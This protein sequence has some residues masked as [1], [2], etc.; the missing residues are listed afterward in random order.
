LPCLKQGRRSASQQAEKGGIIVIKWLGHSSFLIT[1]EKGLKIIT[2]PY[3]IGGGISYARIEESADIVTVS[4]KHGDHN[5]IAAV[6]GKPEAVNA[7]GKRSVKGIDFRGIHSYHDDAGGRQRGSNIIFCFTVD[8]MKICHLGDLGQQLD[9]S[10]ITEIGEVDILLL[11]IGGYFTIDARGAGKICEKLNPRIAI[12]MHYKT[13]KCDY[14]IA[15]VDD[16]IKGKKNVR[17]LDTAEVYLKKDRLSDKTEILVLK[18][19]Q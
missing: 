15:G 10:Q 3:S 19:A 7:P 1:S 8:E 17:K 14:P 4:H 18:H 9:A 12:P 11:P 2:D 16:F 5:N 13:A 6:K